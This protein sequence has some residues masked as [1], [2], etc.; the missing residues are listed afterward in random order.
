MNGIE[1]QAFLEEE[2]GE[3]NVLE[4]RIEPNP[5]PISHTGRE[6]SFTKNGHKV[7]RLLFQ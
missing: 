2:P 6:T 4:G 1:R 3:T 7:L 5:E